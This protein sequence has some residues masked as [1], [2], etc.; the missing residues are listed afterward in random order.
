MNK[1]PTTSTQAGDDTSV[2]KTPLRGGCAKILRI[3]RGIM[4]WPWPVFRNANC[5]AKFGGYFEE[6][7]YCEICEV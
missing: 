5:F 6:K 3:K 1:T 2:T 4:N 7:M